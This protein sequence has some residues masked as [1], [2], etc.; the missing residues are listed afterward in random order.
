LGVNFS[1]EIHLRHSK[2]IVH[3]YTTRTKI[4]PN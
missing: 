1:Q 4:Q 3:P 2:S